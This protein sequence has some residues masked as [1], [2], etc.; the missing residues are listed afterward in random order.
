NV[1]FEKKAAVSSALPISSATET[2]TPFPKSAV[3]TSSGLRTPESTGRSGAYV[4]R[5][6]RRVRASGA[7]VA[8]GLFVVAG[9]IVW[10][11]FRGNAQY[12]PEKQPQDL[13][14]A[15]KVVD[16]KKHTDD[17]PAQAAEFDQTLAQAQR[18]EERARRLEHSKQLD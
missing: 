6:E 2:E 4:R 17:L 15:A 12:Q 8:L 5:P 10:V 18:V 3:K 1:S 11:M 13:V 7:V 9:L 14:T 16:K